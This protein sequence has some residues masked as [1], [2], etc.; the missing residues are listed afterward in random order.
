MSER[1]A[2]PKPQRRV[3]PAHLRAVRL[4]HGANCSSIGSVIDTLFVGA[5]ASGALFAAIAAALSR[6][7]VRGPA[8]PD[9]E[10]R[11]PEEAPD[12]PEGD[13]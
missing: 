8:A 13:P 7:A 4:G 9:A 12:A 10:R 5:V 2:A 3:D 6:E 11:V 1:D